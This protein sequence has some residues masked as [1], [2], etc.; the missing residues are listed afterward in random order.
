M[1][2]KSNLQKRKDDGNS[3]YWRKKAD[4][5]WAS[6]VKEIYGNKCFICGEPELLNAHHAFPREIKAYRW[7]VENSVALC[8][9][10]H[11]YSL[12]LSAHRNPISFF[13]HMAIN[14]K[15]IMNTYMKIDAVLNSEQDYER[16]KDEFKD[17]TYKEIY[18]SLLEFRDTKDFQ[19]CKNKIKQYLIKE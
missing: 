4:A 10:H 3:I 1:K 14:A 8:P 16:L 13:T 15:E 2:K 18:E 17:I 19:E 9:Y 7:N 11:K 6:Y 12:E 5:I